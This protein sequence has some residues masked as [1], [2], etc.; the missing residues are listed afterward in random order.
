MSQLD[1]EF[2]VDALFKAIETADAGAQIPLYAEQAEVQVIDPHHPPRS[3][4]TLRG[5]RAIAG[6]ITDL[7]SIQMSHRV[8]DVVNGGDQVA[9]TE[10]G[11]YRDGAMVV[12]T[13]TLR[14]RGG[15]IL[16]QR[17]VLVWDDLD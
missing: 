11:R 17:V 14:L 16:R 8:V 1:P 5:R 7:C 13:S 2:D 12:S 9:F 6:W 15:L 4:M 10:E 3:P